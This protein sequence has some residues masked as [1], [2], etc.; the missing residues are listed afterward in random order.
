MCH[1]VYLEVKGLTRALLTVCAPPAPRYILEPM[2]GFAV[3]GFLLASQQAPQAD[4]IAKLEAAVRVDPSNGTV[5]KALGM[6]LAAQQRSEP[7]LVAFSRA[8][9]L[10]PKDE[11]SCYFLGRQLFSLSR[12][13]EAVAAFDKAVL[14]ASKEK[15][16]RTHR[17]AA[18]NQ[19]GNGSVEQAVRHFRDAVRPGY[20]P[21]ETL[22]D[23]QTDYGAFLFR[24]ARSKEALA[25]LEQAVKI[26][27]SSARAHAEL[28]RV[29]LHLNRPRESAVALERAVK[30]D[31][32]LSGIHMLLGRAYLAMGRSEEAER[33]LRLGRKQWEGSQRRSTGR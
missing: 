15:L 1:Q 26:N 16:S 3:I 17:A 30:L 9:D 12:Y 6:A 33:Q 21:D 11:D 19:I 10:I 5:W 25:A 22:A 29:L 23:A 28:G 20:G 7:A 32:G 27:P 13:R 8:C 14:A 31:D 24:Q 18:L 2:F 4:D